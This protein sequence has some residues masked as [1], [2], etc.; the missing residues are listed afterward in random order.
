[1]AEQLAMKCQA[2]S[3][4]IGQRQGLLNQGVFC[5]ASVLRQMAA[6]FSVL[7]SFAKGLSGATLQAHS[8]VLTGSRHICYVKLPCISLCLN[9]P[10]ALFVAVLRALCDCNQLESASH[11]VRHLLQIISPPSPPDAPTTAAQLPGPDNSASLPSSSALQ[12]ASQAAPG[13]TSW[14]TQQHFAEDAQLQQVPKPQQLAAPSSS[15]QAQHLPTSA[16]RP[17]WRG[18]VEAAL[19]SN[20]PQS[21]LSSETASAS[22]GANQ[23]AGNS[24]QKGPS[25]PPLEGHMAAAHLQGSSAGRLTS[26]HHSSSLQSS[27]T[28]HVTT[29]LSS[30]QDQ[31]S[32]PES[33]SSQQSEIQSPLSHQRP[34]QHPA[35][36]VAAPKPVQEAAGWANPPKQQLGVAAGG[37]PEHPPALSGDKLRLIREAC[38]VV[39]T[40]AERQGRP[41]MLLPVLEGMQQVH[42]FICPSVRPSIYPFM[43][44]SSQPSI[45]P[46][47]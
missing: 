2:H 37:L 19:D 1:M 25:E 33:T 13:Q 9:P 39:M 6:A 24:L 45:H 35:A 16:D 31:Q 10:D 36:T 20:T 30:R 41:E 15:Q 4:Q 43:L 18:W 12:R 47:S 11:A 32:L 7:F 21:L 40:L 27:P 42:S 8:L 28:P 46:S 23:L 22:E 14:T 34:S 26:P 29:Q 44:T 38:H 3:I 17:G 5:V